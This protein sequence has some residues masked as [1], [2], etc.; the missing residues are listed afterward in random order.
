MSRKWVPRAK[1]QDLIWHILYFMKG[2][3]LNLI[4]GVIEECV[5]EYMLTSHITQHVAKHISKCQLRKL[6]VRLS[7]ESCLTYLY[8]TF[9]ERHG[10]KMHVSELYIWSDMQLQWARYNPVL[11]MQVLSSKKTRHLI[12]SCFPRSIY[13]ELELMG[14][15]SQFNNRCEI[16]F[17][18]TYSKTPSINFTTILPA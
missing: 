9:F 15:F 7:R 2:T 3:S 6:G 18:T 5:V 1:S 10:Y 14:S 4:F 17:T 8:L 16:I 12:R 13:Q 11:T